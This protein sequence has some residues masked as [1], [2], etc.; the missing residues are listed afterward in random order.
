VVVGR[1]KGRVGDEISHAISFR[2]QLQGICVEGK[3]QPPHQDLA[4]VAALAACSAASAVA[5]LVAYS[6]S[7]AHA[8]CWQVVAASWAEI[9]LSTQWKDNEANSIKVYICYMNPFL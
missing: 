9:A 1:S 7:L 2:L 5:V 6:A 4:G 8:G 3:G